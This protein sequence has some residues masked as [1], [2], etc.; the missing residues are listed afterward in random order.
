MC[1]LI[2]GSL[3][4]LPLQV[5]WGVWCDSVWCG[6]ILGSLKFLPLRTK[7]GVWYDNVRCGLI[8]GSLKFLPVQVKWGV[9]CDSVR[10]DLIQ[11]SLKFVPLQVKWGNK[12]WAYSS[13]MECC[14]RWEI[15]SKWYRLLM[16]EMLFQIHERRLK[17]KLCLTFLYKIKTQNLHLSKYSPCNSRSQVNV[18][19]LGLCYLHVE[20]TFWRLKAAFCVVLMFALLLLPDEVP[21]REQLY[22]ILLYYIV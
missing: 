8:Q 11:D 13:K 9:W 17:V 14:Y 20:H 15:T 5:K 2:Q 6:L 22:F 10:C 3:K 19:L 7:W 12:G 1:G 18:L 4:F 16:Y 21:P